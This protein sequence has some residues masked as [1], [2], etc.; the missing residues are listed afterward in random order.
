MKIYA[1]SMNNILGDS[2]K[3]IDG[4]MLELTP[5]Y[6]PGYHFSERF[7]VIPAWILKQKVVAVGP[8][9]E[10]V[11]HRN[12]LIDAITGEKLV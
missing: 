12:I 6:E 1:D 10:I 2:K 7:R 9:G 8:E 4:M 5:V 11:G 3:T